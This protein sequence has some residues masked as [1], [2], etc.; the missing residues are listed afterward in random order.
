[1]KFSTKEAVL[2]KLFATYDYVF[3]GGALANDFLKASGQEVGK[4]LV[5][6]TDERT[7]KKFLSNPKLVLPIDSIIENEKILDHGPGT[8][9]LLTNLAQKAK[10]ILWNGPLGNYESG[11]IDAT[12]AFARAVA[13]SNAYSVVGGG[14]TVASIEHLGLLS[15]FSFVSTGGGA[16]LDFLATGTLPGIEAIER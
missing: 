7:L 2:T 12:D 11:F 1:M 5:S 4:S 9:A 14:D 3:V 10:T 8:S 15:R 13:S 6:D 16:M